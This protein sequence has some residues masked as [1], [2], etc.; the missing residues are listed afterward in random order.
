VRDFCP[1]VRRTEALCSFTDKDLGDRVRELTARHDPQLLPRVSQFLYLKE[2]RSSFEIERERP[3][4]K[5]TT[6]FVELLR[7]TNTISTLSTATLVALQKDILEPRYATDGYRTDQNYVG[8]TLS[9]YREHV[10]FVPPRP[11]DVTP[12]MNGWLQCDVRLCSR[13]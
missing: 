13:S 5:R 6:R 8:E 12:L 3:D 2:I 4:R 7:A 10:R 9:S 11:Q 1:L